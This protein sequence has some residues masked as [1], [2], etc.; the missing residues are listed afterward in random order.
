M[1]QCFESLADTARTHH[2]LFRV[3]QARA[4][5]IERW[6]L[7]MLVRS[8]WC[9]R[10]WR[11]IYRLRGAPDTADQAL[12]VAVWFSGADAVASHRAVAGLSGWP[13]F[14]G[15]WP[16]VTKPRG[17]SQRRPYG[18]VHGS[19]VLP[20][21]HRS[22]RRA[23]PVTTPARTVFDLAG[24]VPRGRAERALDH[25]LN[26]RLCTLAD[27]QQVFFAMARQGRRGTVAMR[28]FLKERGE[29]YV[30]PASELERI[31]RKLFADGGV[32]APAF[33][34]DLGSDKWVGRVDCVWRDERVIVELDSRRHHTGLL[35]RDSDRRRDNELMA[36]GWRVIRVNWA[37]L[38]DR[39]DE[40]LAWIRD[41]L[42]LPSH[43]AA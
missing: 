5:G 41:A 28:E 4:L 25:V 22:V 13:G 17:Q 43:R 31:G 30:A 14:G 34:V 8:G 3:D 12:L 26:E 11:G 18:R 23:I 40:V 21:T 42:Q 38:H 37:D 32:P 33:E 20:A 9:D 2:G 7:D 16:E 27:L 36:A 19:L 39:P 1:D 29:G 15:S 10:P 24:V 35:A 6:R